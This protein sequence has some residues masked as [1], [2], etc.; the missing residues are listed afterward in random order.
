MSDD[1]RLTTRIPE[2]LTS[3]QREVLKLVAA[4]LQDKEIA[5]KLGISYSAVKFH[6]VS[7]RRKFG[8]ESRFKL[9][10]AVCQLTDLK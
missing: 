2:H 8:A 1:G 6:V 3:R 9:V 10:C 7:L 5:S 4:G